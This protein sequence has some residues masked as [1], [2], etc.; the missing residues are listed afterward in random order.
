MEING[1][2]EPRREVTGNISTA[3]L[4]GEITVDGGAEPS[5]QGEKDIHGRVTTTQ[6]VGGNLKGTK[7]LSGDI[8]GDVKN[9]LLKD[10]NILINKPQINGVTLVGNKTSGDLNIPKIYY[11][12]KENW[13]SQPSLVTENKAIYVYW[14]HQKDKDDNDIP[15]VK[16]GTGKEYLTD[17]PFLD[18]IYAE[19][20][21]NTVIHVTQNDRDRWDEKVR[22][23]I[24]PLNENNLIFTTTPSSE[25]E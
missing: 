20:I 13:D 21:L 4:H 8:S 19:H 11:D 16:I 9:R 15:G 22:C 12:T 2:I 10:Y 23:F 6:N 14:N 17:A 5:V 24:D 18:T 1:K 7:A 3:A 25:G